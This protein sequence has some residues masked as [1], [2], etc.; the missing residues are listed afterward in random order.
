HEHESLQDP[1]SSTS[2]DLLLIFR[3]IPLTVQ[4]LRIDLPEPLAQPQHRISLARDERVDADA[5]T[6]R[7]LLEARALQLLRNEDRALLRRQLGQR[8]LQFLEQQLPHQSR[9]R[10]LLYH[11]QQPLQRRV[12]LLSFRGEIAEELRPLLAEA[13][14][15]AIARH[16]HEPG[17]DLLDGLHQSVSRHQLI[18]RLLQDILRLRRIPH[19]PQ[20]ERQQPPPLAPYDRGD[21]EILRRRAQWFKQC[22]IHPTKV[23]GGAVVD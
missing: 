3:T 21:L 17:A 14:D 23:D 15:D 22:G 20:D 8:L 1:T 19:P 13:V 4:P 2:H 7:Q 9:I 10:T 6:R 5:P 11:R 16:P 18:K 12:R